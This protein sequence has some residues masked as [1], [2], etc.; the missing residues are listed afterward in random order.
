MG[1]CLAEFVLRQ[2]DFAPFP[3]DHRAERFLLQI[4]LQGCGKILQFLHR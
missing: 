4:I 1:Y 2:M 3:V